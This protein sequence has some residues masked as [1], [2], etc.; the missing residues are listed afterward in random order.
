MSIES[1]YLI[2]VIPLSIIGFMIPLYFGKAWLGL[3]I[4]LLLGMIFMGT[5]VKFANL[6]IKSKYVR[7]GFSVYALLLVAF[8]ALAFAHDYGRKD[9]Q[10]ELLLEIR[11]TIEEGITKNAVQR[12]LIYVLGEY[13]KQDENSIIELAEDI[14]E[15]NLIEN[16]EFDEYPELEEPDDAMA[17]Y[18]N[19]NKQSGEFLVIGVSKVV[20]GA[21]PKFKNY[22][23]STGMMELKLVLKESG[24]SYEM[25]N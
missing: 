7:V 20:P 18:Y 23:G 11:Q 15:D 10:K 5:L 24:V 17:Y 1:K 12:E 22:D 16:G 21:D 2:V 6:N 8:H 13:H 25:A 9:Y 3:F 19:S 14:L 4:L